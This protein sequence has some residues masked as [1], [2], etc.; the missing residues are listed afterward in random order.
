MPLPFRSLTPSASSSAT[1]PRP[2]TKEVA[3]APKKEPL[4]FTD[5]RSSQD[6]SNDGSEVDQIS[7]KL[8]ELQGELFLSLKEDIAEW[9]TKTLGDDVQI[10]AQNFIHALDTGVILCTLSMAIE[11][12]AREAYRQGVIKEPLPDYKLH[13]N[14]TAKSGTWFARDNTANFL[15]WCRTFGMTDE[16]LFDSED[17][18]THHQERQVIYCLM[19]LARLGAR[20]GLEPPTLISMEKEIDNEEPLPLPP[21]MRA[22]PP[23]PHESPPPTPPIV[24]KSPPPTPTPPPR[25]DST[26]SS[27]G[28]TLST[29]DSEV[30]RVSNQCKC[31]EYVNKLSEGVY[32]V[33]GK[34][35]FIRLLKGKHLMVR[36]GGGWDTFENYLLHHDPIQV[37]EFHQ[38]GLPGSSHST[39]SARPSTA[40][41]AHSHSFAVARNDFKPDEPPSETAK[42]GFLRRMRRNYKSAS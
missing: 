7:L 14:K 35:V 32:N 4:D 20:F 6:L 22:D 3:N 36:V 21:P 9:I 27:K 11:E 40:G 1:S 38:G 2:I 12:R 10:D 34:R 31:Q 23:T 15:K 39:V 33:F 37:F 17:L 16:T 30:S 5:G 18:V 41:P 24:E 19:E 28:S 29:L 8:S 25:K 13:C 26:G 42:E